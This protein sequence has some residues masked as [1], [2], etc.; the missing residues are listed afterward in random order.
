[1][2]SSQGRLRKSNASGGVGYYTSD[3]PTS[4]DYLVQA[5]LYVKS[6]VSTAGVLGRLDPGGSST[7]TY[8][9]ARY[10]AGAGQFQLIRNLN[11]AGAVLGTYSQTLT[12]GSSYRL[13]LDMKGTTI[14]M[15]VNDVQRAS[16]T[17]SVLTAAGRAGVGFG[18][19][20]DTATQSDTQGLH[21]DNFTTSATIVDSSG[22]NDGTY[23]GGPSG[24]TPGA[25]SNDSDTAVTFDGG[26]EYGTAARQIADDL[27]IELWFKSTQG[28]GTG[29][30]WWEGA[31]MVDAEVATAAND[32]GVSLRSDGK[33]V[34]GVGSPTTGDVSVVSSSGGFNDGSWHHVVFTR[35]RSSGA[36]KL[37]VD[38]ALL[39][40]ATASTNSL[41]AQPTLSFGRLATGVNAYAG[42]LD[43]IAVYNSALSAATVS[44]HYAAR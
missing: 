10:D 23:L 28:I 2:L 43:E 4:P 18:E 42:A 24:G 44:S 17:D 25:L 21:L 5:D 16:V 22:T 39:G 32:F 37:Y 3:V 35:V 9:Y 19:P 20:G 41:T 6:V 36:I 29:A 1:V 27:S 31:G 14:R 40:S 13:G 15:L 34:G 7:G 33:L 12:V 30:Q 8:Y 38:G 26:S 11:G